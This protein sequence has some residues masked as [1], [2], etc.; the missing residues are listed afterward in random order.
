MKSKERFYRLAIPL[1]V[2]LI[3][4]AAISVIWHSTIA[5]KA[6]STVARIATSAPTGLHV[7]SNTIEDHSGKVIIPHGVDRMGSEYSCPSGNTFDGPTD[8]AS[9]NAM[10]TWNVSIVRLPMNEDCWLGIN[11]YPGDSRTALE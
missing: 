10:L 4:A 2:V 7:V 11:G 3:C 5:V 9:V 1:L 6:A 8:Q